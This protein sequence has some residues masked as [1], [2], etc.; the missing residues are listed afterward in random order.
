MTC[1]TDDRGVRDRRGCGHTR[2]AKH[3]QS[4][5]QNQ[6]EV[7]VYTKS[8]KANHKV[9]LYLTMKHEA[10]NGKIIVLQFA[11]KI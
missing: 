7:S 4:N 3:H 8:S 9:L 2:M 6:I 10:T 11:N 1:Q 5:K